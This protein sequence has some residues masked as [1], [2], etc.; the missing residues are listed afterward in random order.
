MIKLSH[1]GDSKKGGSEEK[2]AMSFFLCGN[3]DGGYA[4]LCELDRPR[5]FRFCLATPGWHNPSAG[6]CGVA[7][8]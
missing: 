1:V 5:R 8:Q 3:G 4:R 2:T 6:I 7:K